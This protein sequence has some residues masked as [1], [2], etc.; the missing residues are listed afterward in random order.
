MEWRWNWAKMS[1]LRWYEYLWA[2]L[3]LVLMVAG[4]AIGGLC[5]AVAMAINAKLMAGGGGG[6]RKYG[7]TGLVSLASVAAYVTL[8]RVFVATTGLGDALGRRKRPQAE[9][10]AAVKTFIGDATRRYLPVA[11]DE[12]VIKIARVLILEVDQLAAKSADACFG[13]LFP[14]PNDPPVDIT[15]FVTTEV[16]GLDAAAT[17]AI[18]ESGAADPRPTPRRED[19]AAPLG[20]A[21]NRVVANYGAADVAALST[22]ATMDKA[23]ACAVTSAVYKEVLSL[24]QS[25]VGPVLRFM[26]A[27]SA[28]I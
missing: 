8:V 24:P 5:A 12:A 20:D 19:V 23:R 18:L 15:K 14:T 9:I 7:G 17:V 25:D 1:K 11:S 28:H 13:F 3:P 26:F 22:P 2:G 10:D 21:V 6:L 16:I 27:Q 4:G